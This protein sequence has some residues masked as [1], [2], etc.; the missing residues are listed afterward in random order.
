MQRHRPCTYIDFDYPSSTRSE[1]LL[2]TT[3]GGSFF[4]KILA[5]EVIF[6]FHY[7][8]IL[9]TECLNKLMIY[10]FNHNENMVP[11]YKRIMIIDM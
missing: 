1:F 10:F 5:R 7:M 9:I 11:I 4:R 8:L 2:H 6:K 3:N